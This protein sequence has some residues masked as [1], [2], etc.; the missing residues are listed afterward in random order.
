SRAVRD[1]LTGENGAFKTLSD[2]AIWVEMSTNSKS[3]IFDLANIGAEKGIKTIEAPV[4]GGAHRAPTGNIRI[5]VG[6]D[7]QLFDRLKPLF[8]VMG[9]IVLHVGKLG[10]A[11]NMKLITNMLV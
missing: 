8:E 11:T 2:G 4:T 9:G 5:L 7:M 1:V 10:D 6:G 3:E